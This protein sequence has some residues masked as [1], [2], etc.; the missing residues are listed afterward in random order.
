MATREAETQ[1]KLVVRGTD[2]KYR[3]KRPSALAGGEFYEVDKVTLSDEGRMVPAKTEFITIAS[4]LNVVATVGVGDAIASSDA[5]VL[6]A[7][8]AQ[9][10][11]ITLLE[12]Y[13]VTVV[14]T[15]A[16]ATSD[17]GSAVA[18]IGEGGLGELG[19]GGYAS[20]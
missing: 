9:S 8:S 7:T 20:D 2:V 19:L 12:T 13:N 15:S 14:G 18:G 10:D 5:F 1:F 16:V 4:N 17:V 11:A 3:D 6:D